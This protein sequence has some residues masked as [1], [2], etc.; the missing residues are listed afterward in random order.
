MI[1]LKEKIILKKI[2][3][4]ILKNYENQNKKTLTLKF[5]RSIATVKYK[6]FPVYAT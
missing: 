2:Y 3:K 5:Q 6:T 1:K 4:K